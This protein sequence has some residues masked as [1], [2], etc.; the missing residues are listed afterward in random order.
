MW[1]PNPPT[2]K[3]ITHRVAALNKMAHESQSAGKA[4]PATTPPPSNV[5]LDT[6]IGSPNASPKRSIE[7]DQEITPRR[8]PKR[9][10]RQNVK[11]IEPESED[12]DDEEWH[13]VKETDSVDK[14]EW[15][16]EGEGADG[17]NGATIEG[18]VEAEEAVNGGVETLMKEE[19]LGLKVENVLESMLEE[20]EH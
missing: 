18:E 1:G 5:G 2:L 10:A 16:P 14:Y 8:M 7:S 11:Y 19:D 15:T 4:T 9:R 13:Q 6:P 12:S 3:A 20:K 17:G